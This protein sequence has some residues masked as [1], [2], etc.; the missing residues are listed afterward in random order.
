MIHLS[1]AA[2]EEVNRLRAKNP[3]PDGILRLGVKAGGCADFYYTLQ[4]DE[5]ETLESSDRHWDCS[6]I[7][8]VVSANDA[9]YLDGL[10]LDYSED[11]MGGGFRFHNPN[12]VQNCG[13]G[14][15]FAIAQH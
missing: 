6:G 10:T 14:N 8:V 9:G 3:K 2:I 1:Q 4:F 5:A 11:L 7:K 12:A 15:S 13:C